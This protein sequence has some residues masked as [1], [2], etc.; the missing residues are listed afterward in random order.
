MGAPAFSGSTFSE[1]AEVIGDAAARTLCEK[2]GGTTIYVPA[3]I[4]PNHPLGVALGMKSAKIF[5]DHFKGAH[6][7]L[8]KAHLR[9][10]RVIE[11]KRTTDMTIREIALAT[12]YTERHVYDILAGEAEDDGQLDL[13]DQR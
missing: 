9:R 3:M 13:F 7:Q 4:G 11:L 1:I 6:L 5:A 10:Q 8:P 2:L 12:D